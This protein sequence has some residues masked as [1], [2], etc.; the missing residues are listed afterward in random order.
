M[1]QPLCHIGKA[2]R[3]H[4]YIHREFWKTSWRRCSKLRF[5]L[6]NLEF[7]IHDRGERILS[8]AA[9]FQSEKKN[10]MR[11]EGEL[12]SLGSG[13]KKPEYDRS[14]GCGQQR[15]VEGVRWG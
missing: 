11:V 13:H 6:M 12:G 10:G 8:E 3:L 2:Y 5:G 9:A 4:T 7:I 14:L 1:W 15:L